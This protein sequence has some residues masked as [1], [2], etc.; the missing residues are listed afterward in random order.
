MISGH[1][2]NV[3][4]LIRCGLCPLSPQKRTVLS[5]IGIS[6]LCQKQTSAALFDYLVGAVTHGW[7]HG[8]AERIS[9]LEIDHQ[10]E[11]DRGLD[12]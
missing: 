8:E 10:F 4:W 9:A 11:L 3:V 5:A 6:A 7:R 2:D 1:A 12:G